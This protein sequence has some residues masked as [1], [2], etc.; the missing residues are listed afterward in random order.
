MINKK[1]YK[2]EFQNLLY[3]IEEEKKKIISLSRY[4]KKM[5]PEMDRLYWEIN[6]PKNYK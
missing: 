6:N 2:K 4:D 3:G 1:D 5:D